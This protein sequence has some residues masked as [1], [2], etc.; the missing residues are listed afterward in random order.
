M[1]PGLA[2]TPSDDLPEVLA[3]GA[4]D[5]S[6]VFVSLS[7]RHPDGRDADY[8]A[9]HALDHR[10]EQYRLPGMQYAE[11]LV[12][13]PECRAA[14]AASDPRFDAVDH[15]MTYFFAD[16]GSL[17]PFAAL[18]A[19]L[20]A[21]GRMPLRL[22]SV[23][24]AVFDVAGRVAAPRARAGADVIP[25]RPARGAYLLVEEGGGAA[26]R[27]LVAVAGVAGAW[28]Y[29]GTLGP[30]P[31]STDHCDLRLT[32]CYLDDD[33]VAVAARLRQALDRRWRADRGRPLLAAPFH[34]PEPYAWDRFVP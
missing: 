15:V 9:W 22:P 18:G 13:T 6:T 31:F 26:P 25:W 21:G 29:T 3:V 14:R 28:W 1:N 2:G 33:P 32:V 11:R 30:A 24:V 10:P 5:V 23:E 20:H 12:S 19:A 8:L 34:I 27:D 17:G 4:P 7:A 16:A